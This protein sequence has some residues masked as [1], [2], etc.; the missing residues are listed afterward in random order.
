M[1]LGPVRTYI[2]S[3]NAF[4]TPGTRDEPDR[5]ALAGRIE[6]GL[7]EA[8]GFAIPVVLRTVPELETELAASP[9]ADARP[10]E[11]ERFSVVFASGPLT[12]DG[13][14]AR[15]PR[16]DWELAGVAGSTAYVVWRL[17]DGRPPANPIPLI[18]K[19]CGVRATGR[20]FHTAQK[21]LAA[22][23]EG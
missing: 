18:E 17:L 8:F 11:N 6:T 14:P 15:S 23:R 4:F 21:I 20:F 22:A 7:A 13:L 9:F 5:V 12:G 19:A 3:G 10:A 16:G 1:G 2:A